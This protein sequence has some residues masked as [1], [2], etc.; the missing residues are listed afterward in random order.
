MV[1]LCPF[2]GCITSFLITYDHIVKKR[3]EPKLCQS[4]TNRKNINLLAQMLFP[5]WKKGVFVLTGIK[6]WF[7]LVRLCYLIRVIYY[8]QQG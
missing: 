7:V 1:L 2:S 8:L 4:G 5:H 3:K 6:D